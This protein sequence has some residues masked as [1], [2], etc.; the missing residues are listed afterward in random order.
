MANY[1][2]MD[3]KQQI[4]GLLQLGWSYRRIEK[5]TGVRRETV[6][7]YH[8]EWLLKAAKVPTGSADEPVSLE[9]NTAIPPMYMSADFGRYGSDILNEMAYHDLLGGSAAANILG[10]AEG[11]KNSMVGI[12]EALYATGRGLW[13]FATGDI[14]GGVRV[15]EEHFAPIADSIGQ[16]FTQEYWSNIADLAR[17][18]PLVFNRY[19]G[20]AGGA[21]F[22]AKAIGEGFGQLGKYSVKAGLAR[23]GLVN[24][25]ILLRKIRF[26]ERMPQRF[27]PQG[28]TP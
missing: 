11:I 19:L 4:Y 13:H 24:S 2:K 17:E 18:D 25:Y 12:G 3:K 26:W 6:S 5:E 10:F 9:T 15:F 8:R 20:N 27:N 28:K 14:Q 23:N 1:L 7:R 22:T 16:M 21:I